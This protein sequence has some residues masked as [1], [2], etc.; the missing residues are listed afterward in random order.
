[1]FG[2]DLV[3]VGGLFILASNSYY[4]QMPKPTEIN[5]L[6]ETHEIQ[7]DFSHTTEDLS[8][9]H[10][11]TVSPY[12]SGVDTTTG[13]L[14]HDAPVVQTQI[15]WGTQTRERSGASCIW[16]DTVTVKITLSPTIYIASDYQ[17]DVCRQAIL[18]HEER[19]VQV[20]RDVMNR[21]AQRLGASLQKAVRAAGAVGPYNV[22]QQDD[23]EQKM[24]TYIQNTIKIE[25]D[26]MHTEMRALQSQV[27][28]LDEYER[29][30]KICNAAERAVGHDMSRPEKPRSS[31]RG[32]NN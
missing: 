18:E 15:K 7:Y 8:A 1:M 20:D 6:P 32:Y 27:D 24:V 11:N 10:S 30:S 23:M 16:Y 19:H 14:R 5:I 26:A 12:A 3:T 2:L 28:S 22:S 25:E 13:G 17:S 29:V 4:C 21:F 31:H 9:V